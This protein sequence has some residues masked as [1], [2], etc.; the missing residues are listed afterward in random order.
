MFNVPSRRKSWYLSFANWFYW[1]F[2]CIDPFPRFPKLHPV[3]RHVARGLFL[4]IGC[5]R[6][7]E[8]IVP[9]IAKKAFQLRLPP[10]FG[11]W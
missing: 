4:M 5:D 6:T 11:R 1:Q 2:K 8:N 7:G 10:F 3:T 9:A